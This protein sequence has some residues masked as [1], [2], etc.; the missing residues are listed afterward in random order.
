MNNS[1]RDKFA[2]RDGKDQKQRFKAIAQKIIESQEEKSY[3]KI[4]ATRGF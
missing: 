3:A 4:S 1:N 2:V